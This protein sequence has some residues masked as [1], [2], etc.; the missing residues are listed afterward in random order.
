MNGQKTDKP[1]KQLKMKVLCLATFLAVSPAASGPSQAAREPQAAITK[2]G[3]PIQDKWAVVIGCSHFADQRVPTLKYS[4][5]DAQDFANYL[6]DPK[7]GK[8]KKDHVKVLTNEDASKVNIMDTIGDSFLPH[9]AMPGDLVV[10]YLS[11]HG[12][13]A[14]ADIRGVNY[15]IAYDTS[16][17]KLFATGIEMKQLLRIIKE[18]VHTDRILLIMDTCYSGAGAST[19]AGHKGLT[20]TN[21]DAQSI[22]QGCGSLVISSSLPNQRAWESDKLQNSFFTHY[23]IESLEDNPGQITI[24]Q[25]FNKMSSKVQQGVLQ[26]KGEMQTPAMS[27]VFK[28]P[29]LVL[30]RATICTTSVT[31]Y[32]LRWCRH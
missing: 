21:V 32:R 14:G 31:V 6:T 26:E 24:D 18:R 17:D 27:G 25:A 13:P 9:A 8:F 29:K 1:I 7:F 23:L 2:L 3:Q 20:R 11:T 19:E 5:K 4:A 16:V 10:I 12:S 28:G 15:V 22:A 30:R